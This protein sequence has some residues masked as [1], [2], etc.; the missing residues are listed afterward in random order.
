[1]SECLAAEAAHMDCVSTD[2]FLCNATPVPEIIDVDTDK[3]I[4]LNT[5][6]SYCQVLFAGH[7]LHTACTPEG[8]TQLLCTRMDTALHT[9]STRM[10][11]P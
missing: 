2:G 10:L 5:H 11:Y 4:P 7:Q 3:V 6:C 8:D 9:G 1:M